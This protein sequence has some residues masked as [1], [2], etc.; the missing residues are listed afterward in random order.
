MSPSAT[1]PREIYQTEY[2]ISIQ[3]LWHMLLYAWNE[4]PDLKYSNLGDVD[5][6]PTLDA[7]LAL[8]LTKLLRQR[9]RIGLGQGYTNEQR[10]I[11]AIRGRIN[12]TESLKRHAFEQGQ[13][14]CEFQPYSQN[15]LKNQIIRSTLQYLIQSGNFGANRT[16]ANELRHHLQILFRQ[17]EGIDLI[18]LTPDVIRRQMFERDDRDY[19]LMLAI[20]ELIAQRQ[21]P[22][23]SAGTHI[24]PT[25]ERDALTLHSIYE[26]FVAN[27]Y[28]LHL[29]GWS[30]SA[31]KHLRWH[32]T[33]SNDLLPIMRPDLM[34]EEKSS[35]RILIIDTKFTTQ[36]IIQNQWGKQE[37][38][39][40][41][42]YQLYAYLKTQEHLSESHR[43]AE[44]ILLYPCVAGNMLSQKIQL[45]DMSIRIES[46]DLSAA[47]QEI[48][49]Q[50]LEIITRKI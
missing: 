16:Q 46:V 5:N 40:S 13:A 38:D 35:G 9:L 2:G 23:D 22:T 50:L 49:K 28:R 10:L 30:V 27:F 14:Y 32:E 47:W 15:I 3:N 19:R 41:H 6:S 48:E 39:S 44:G 31:Q 17:L 1:A 33:F 7:L 21:M 8:M 25:L 12:F 42:L 37:F 24:Q 36:S 4:L 43:Q 20:C 11:H 34:L 26:R 45:Q 18:E 29:K